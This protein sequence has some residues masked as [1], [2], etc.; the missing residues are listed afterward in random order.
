M[1]TKTVNFGEV[2]IWN[3]DCV[4]FQDINYQEDKIDRNLAKFIRE[5]V[6]PGLYQSSNKLWISNIKIRLV[7][8][9][10]DLIQ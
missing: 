1:T 8:Y 3:K 6:W 9:T 7:I 4:E 2:E 5:F 10:F